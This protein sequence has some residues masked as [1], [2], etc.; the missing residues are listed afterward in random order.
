M[1][2][3]RNPSILNVFGSLLLYELSLIPKRNVKQNAGTTGECYFYCLQ[4]EPKTPRGPRNAEF[5][6]LLL[7]PT[8]RRQK[9]TIP[10]RL[11]VPGTGPR[12]G[13][14]SKVVGRFHRPKREGL[15]ELSWQGNRLPIG[16]KYK[17]G[18]V[19]GFGT[20]GGDPSR[21]GWRS[22]FPGPGAWACPEVAGTV[23]SRRVAAASG[24]RHA[25]HRLGQQGERQDMA[26]Q[27]IAGHSG[28]VK[29]AAGG[30]GLWMGMEAGGGR[31]RVFGEALEG[32][33][34]T[35]AGRVQGSG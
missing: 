24:L 11:W 32:L 35:I 27:A 33:L 6:S 1:F 18:V 10:R 3:K 23:V 21:G 28:R 25:E 5:P 7:E 17:V 34:E 9:T 13:A 19:L 20:V 26:P 30:R 12:K 31:V 29:A 2:Y 8:F 16:C 4:W 14:E 22:N 15:P